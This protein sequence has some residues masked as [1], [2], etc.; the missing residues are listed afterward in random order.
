MFFTHKVL[1]PFGVAAL[2]ATGGACP[3]GFRPP[4]T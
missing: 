4:L 3:V 2:L 1:V